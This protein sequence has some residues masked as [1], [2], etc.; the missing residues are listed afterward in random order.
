MTAPTLLAQPE[1]HGL[2]IMRDVEQGT[3]SWHDQRRGMVTASVVG[4]LISVGYL[5]A[6][7][8]DCPE[9]GSAT[10]GPC[11][12]KVKKA[13]ETGA[14]IKTF[15]GARTEVALSNRG[16]DA[17]VLSTSTGDDARGLTL[18]LA[19]ERITGHTD[20]TYMS[21]DMWRGVESEPFARDVYSQ[22]F[23]PV[24]QVGFMVREFDGFRIG[25]SPDGL[26]GDDGLIEVKSRRQKTQL[27]TILDGQ[28]PAD[29]MAQIQCGLF[30]SGRAW[31]DYVS[32]CGGMRM[33]PKRVT[34]D[35]RWFDAILA[36]VQRFEETAEQ[37][38]NTYQE[39]T[40]GLPDTQRLDLEVV[41]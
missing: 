19:A 5:G 29:N 18:L 20:P 32:Y 35:S 4:R 28:V 15:H 33:W 37:M 21:S 3:E 12:S 9:C 22:H 11:I 38:V 23:A 26:V 39:A 6:D 2:T 30:V 8:Y 16:P 7:G 31:C 36:A 27:A 24:T 14:P 40:H 25:Y 10:G 13:G 17:Q 41:I 34:P 1:H